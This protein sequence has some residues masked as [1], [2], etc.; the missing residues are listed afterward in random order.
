MRL[1]A[2]G[3]CQTVVLTSK[4]RL[5]FSGRGFQQTSATYGDVAVYGS[6]RKSPS[7]V[8]ISDQSPQL[9]VIDAAAVPAAVSQARQPS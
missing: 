3:Q 5:M 9:V 7:G 4:G 6:L 1:I 2:C 8:A